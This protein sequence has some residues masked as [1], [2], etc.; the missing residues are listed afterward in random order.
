MKDPMDGTTMIDIALRR[1]M[2]RDDSERQYIFLQEQRGKRSFLIV[3]GPNE[4]QEIQRVVLGQK[5][6]RPLTHQLAY[7][8][9]RALGADL[10]RVDIVDMRNNTY[11]A[12]LVL[13]DKKGELTAVVDARPSD[14]VALALRAKC[15][16]RI[17]ESV[18]EQVR[19]D[20]DGPDPLPPAD[21]ETAE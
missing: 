4:A 17:A 13:Q 10:K 16:L 9:I 7:E 1:I 2:I 12:Q 11:F 21:T 20:N 8:A 6:E 19:S 14:A 15:P 18:L 3:I 5:P